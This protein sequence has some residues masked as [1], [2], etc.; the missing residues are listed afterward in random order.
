MS[1]QSHLPALIISLSYGS[2]SNKI[3]KLE[4]FKIFS[5][6]KCCFNYFLQQNCRLIEK[7]NKTNEYTN[8]C[9]AKCG[10]CPQKVTRKCQ[11]ALK[12]ALARITLLVLVE[13]DGQ[14]GAATRRLRLDEALFS[15]SLFH[16]ILAQILSLCGSIRRN[17]LYLRLEGVC[18]RKHLGKI[19]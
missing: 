4:A 8:N 19:P 1:L 5:L 3:F 15:N 18:G 7:K 13:L 16:L 2:V 9:D 12:V 14:V 17:G 6:A 10:K 11:A